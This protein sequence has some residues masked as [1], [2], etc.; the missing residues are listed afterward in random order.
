MGEV[1]PSNTI[2]LIL[3]AC[4]FFET[5]KAVVVVRELMLARDLFVSVFYI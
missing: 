3:R 2:S 5:E 1:K 4:L